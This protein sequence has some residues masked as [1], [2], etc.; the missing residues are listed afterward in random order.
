MSGDDI[1][2]D[3]FEDN[4]SKTI[5]GED[6]TFEHL[7]DK[8]DYLPVRL[9]PGQKVSARVISVS[10]EL[11][12]IDLPGKTEGIIDSNEFRNEEGHLQ[13]QPGDEIEA[14]FLSVRNGI[15]KL[16]TLI[17]GYPAG[18]VKVIRDA[19]KAGLP[20]DGEVMRS[21][22]GGFEISVGGVKCF[23]PYSQIDVKADRDTRKYIGKGF[24]FM[25]LEF[26]DDGRNIV[27]SRRILIEQ[28]RQARTE[29]LQNTLEEGMKVTAVVSSIQKFGCFVDLGGIDGFVPTRE[30]SWDRINHPGEIV[31]IG[32]QITAKI[33]SLD[34][35]HNRLVFSIKAIQPDPWEDVSEKYPVGS[36]ITGKIVRLV[37]FG[38]F[39][40]LEPGIDGLIH[41]SNL[42]TGRRINHPKEVVEI[43]QK[44]EAYIVD[45]NYENRKIAL[46]L[47]PKAEPKKIVLP[48]AGD[49][50]DGIVD[51]IMPYGIFLKMSNGLNG[52][53]P[54]AEMGTA[55][56][57]D[58]KKLF[59]PGTEMPAI[60]IEVDKS[61]NK[62]RLS[63]KAV[64][65]KEV[66]EEYEEYRNEVKKT[67]QLSGGF[68]SL[69]EIL[70]AKLAEKE[71][72][73]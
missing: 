35:E 64:L 10:G 7:L 12:Y 27:V 13:V 60:V 45:A 52:L 51:H 42:G 5:T 14:Y 47:Q 9:S 36:R 25:V 18:K 68:G 34:W 46:S 2:R 6:E 54:N 21:V 58:H 44:V 43:G 50:I 32:Q 59:P 53:I 16:T 17:H 73:D 66:Q 39:V 37:P 3:S 55:V 15:R 30:M 4:E 40:R 57:T 28:E 63:R 69:G 1:Q 29:R 62:V 20:I 61:N 70:K 22:K 38:A 49:R 23:C 33:L 26:K 48:E 24:P 71:K 31:S 41:I 8:S 65:E 72:S 11:V 67:E 19:H 56:G